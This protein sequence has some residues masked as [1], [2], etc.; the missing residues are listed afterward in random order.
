M[1]NKGVQK[2]VS[3]VMCTYNGEKFIREQ[4]DSIINQ[5]YPISELIIQDDKSVDNTIGIIQEYA[6]K[7]TFIKLYVNKVQL[8][9]SRNFQSAFN[10]ATSPFISVA[11]QDDIWCPDKLEVLFNSIGDN[12]LIYS[13]SL[14]FK[15]NNAVLPW[16]K[17]K[18]LPLMKNY[19][20]QFLFLQNSIAGHSLLFK[21]ECLSLIKDSYWDIL[22]YDYLLA[23]VAMGLNKIAYCDKYLT[24]W[25][26]HENAYSLNIGNNNVVQ[27][28]IG[29]YGK[30]LKN[31][32]IKE[33]K[34]VIERYYTLIK[35]LMLTGSG[36]KY[37]VS[38]LSDLKLFNCFRFSVYSFMNRR[39]ICK[40]LKPDSIKAFI[41]SFLMLLLILNNVYII[42]PFI[43]KQKK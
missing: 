21:K 38:L 23:F 32:F 4:L 41:R 36:Y 34:I 39:S 29:G 28:K 10:K 2:N 14:E 1:M 40:Q 43:S 3:V 6:N 15:D 8:G 27:S 37:S 42:E 35:D 5:T 17:V 11:D 16:S 12:V 30:G 31:L 18:A 20:M 26:R 33:K 9:V 24:L 22:P 19:P 25:R 13:N 7:Y